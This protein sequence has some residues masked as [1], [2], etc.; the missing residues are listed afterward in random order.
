MAAETSFRSRFLAGNGSRPLVL[1]HRGASALETEN[2]LAAFQ[3]ALAE[4]ADGVELDVQR[5]ATG[6]VVVFHD[7]DLARLAGRPERVDRM[8]LEAL[9]EVRL[10]GGGEIATLAE[11]LAACGDAAL[12]N[13]EIKYDGLRP[14]GC[15]ALVAG[16]ADTVGRAAA[17]ARVLVSSFSPAA[18]W[19]WQRLRP[20]VPCGLLCER[21]RPFH[22]PWP[23]RIDWILP[24]LRPAAV[25]PED[26]LCRPA[27]VRG[28]RH[29]GYAVNVW[30]VDEPGRIEE[31]AALG[32]SGIITNHPA[33][34]RSALALT[35]RSVGG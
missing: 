8:P 15:R 7:D 3:R 32:V 2:T 27:A 26:G 31:L 12:V 30:T 16:V 20:D 1:A 35:P 13:I 24:L 19:L 5:C 21:P 9:R 4:G 14:A 6:E 25:H 33:R 22:R 34:A 29:R 28:W 17:A 10:R 18:V 23:L 11:A